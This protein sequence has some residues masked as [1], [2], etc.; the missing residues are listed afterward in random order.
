MSD[1]KVGL[2]ITNI[3][4]SGAKL[5]VCSYTSDNVLFDMKISDITTAIGE[6]DSISLNLNLK[7]AAYVKAFVWHNLTDMQPLTECVEL[8]M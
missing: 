5:I 4:G 6:T 1:E 8:N 3:S 7:N 2:N